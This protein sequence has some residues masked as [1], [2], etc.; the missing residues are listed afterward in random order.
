MAYSTLTHVRLLIAMVFRSRIFHIAVLLG[1]D[2]FVSRL[3]SFAEE[4]HSSLLALFTS[5]KEESFV[6]LSSENVPF[7]F[8]WKMM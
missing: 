3:E 8:K 1:K 2:G 6:T 5:D 7:T 4:K